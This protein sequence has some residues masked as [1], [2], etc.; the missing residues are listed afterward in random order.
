MASNEIIQWSYDFIQNFY[1]N[2]V[3]TISDT[4][5]IYLN[6][7]SPFGDKFYGPTNPVLLLGGADLGQLMKKDIW[8]LRDGLIPLSVFFK[9][10]TLNE[11]K[12]NLLIHKDLWFLVPE[13]WRNSVNYYSIEANQRFSAKQ[14]PKKLIIMGSP[15]ETLADPEEFCEDVEYLAKKL[16]KTN[17]EKMDIVGFFPNKRT[18]LWGRWQ[19]ENIFGYSKVLFKNLKLDIHFPE[20]QILKSEMNL[21]D[22]LYYEINRGHFI[23]DTFPKHLFLSRGAGL[24]E[25][26]DEKSPM[27]PTN[28]VKLSLYHSMQIYKLDEKN[29]GKYID[30]MSDELMPYL[31]KIIEKGTNPR[32]VGASWEKWFGTFIKKHYKNQE[33]I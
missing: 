33:L 25:S 27:I 1:L 11:K 21:S 26:E 13:K 6:Y 23:K 10:N 14:P 15:N 5:K 30:P 18:D 3:E 29:C 8:T 28:N 16:G 7:L 17:I 4:E 20:W 22:T 24:L 31:R 12:L 2:N 19:D 32:N 9:E